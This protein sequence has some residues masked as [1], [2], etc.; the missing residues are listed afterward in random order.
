VVAEKAA[1][2]KAA[3][4]RAAMWESK[5]DSSLSWFAERPAPPKAMVSREIMWPRVAVLIAHV[6]NCQQQDR[7]RRKVE[8]RQK[9]R[10]FAPRALL[11][12]QELCRNNRALSREDVRTMLAELKKEVR[13]RI[14]EEIIGK[15]NA[16]GVETD[17]KLG[18]SNDVNQ[19]I[20]SCTVA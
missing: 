19:G 14:Y 20:S 6:K 12:A 9:E 3:K 2:K 18:N 11:D 10:I 16:W 17:T 15:L 13:Q 5:R 8:D 7:A 4:A 1:R